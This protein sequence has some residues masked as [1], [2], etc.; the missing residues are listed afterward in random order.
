MI[1]LHTECG[2]LFISEKV[3]KEFRVYQYGLTLIEQANEKYRGIKT[4]LVNTYHRTI[5]N[6]FEQVKISLSKK[7]KSLPNP[8]TF[9]IET[10]IKLPWNESLLPVTKRSFVRYLYQNNLLAS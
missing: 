2:Y 1:P 5:S 7:H 3:N 4:M 10:D 6:T 8:A 9:L